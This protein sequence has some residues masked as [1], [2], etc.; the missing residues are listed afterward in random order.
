MKKS[1]PRQA[2]LE[3][4]RKIPFSLN[5]RKAGCRS[6]FSGTRGLAPAPLRENSFCCTGVIVAQMRRK[7]KHFSGENR[8]NLH[9]FAEET[10]NSG[11]GS[12]ATGSATWV[13]NLAGSRCWGGPSR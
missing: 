5:L 8:K 3:K 2:L 1:L 6:V 4:I 12:S 11:S 7:F 13:M 9:H 10:G